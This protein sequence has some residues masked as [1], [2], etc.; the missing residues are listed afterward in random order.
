MKYLDKDKILESLRQEWLQAKSKEERGNI[1]INAV[2]IK[3]ASKCYECDELVTQD[4]HTWP[5]CSPAHEEEWR[6]SNRHTN[7]ARP[8]RTRTLKEIQAVLLKM[9]G[10]GR[11]PAQ[12]SLIPTKALNVD[13]SAWSDA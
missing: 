2:L 3:E 11:A 6:A 13:N 12:T 7:S 5:H 1:E 10:K 8:T 9:A 4:R